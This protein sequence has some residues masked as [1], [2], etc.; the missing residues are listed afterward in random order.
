MTDAPRRILLLF[1]IFAVATG[2][3]LALR[4]RGGYGLFD[5]LRGR[6]P[7]RETV[8]TGDG[9]FSLP[10]RAAVAPEDVPVL[11]RMSDEI[12]NV[13]ER[14]LP[15]VVSIAASEVE[16]AGEGGEPSVARPRLGAGVIVTTDGHVMTNYHVVHGVSGVLVRLANDRLLPAQIVGASPRAD[17]A[18][19]KIITPEPETFQALP[20]IADSDT[21]RAG[22]FVLSIGNPYG[23]RRSVALGN[24]SAK[25]RRFSDGSA[26]L[27]QVSTPMVPGNSGGPL[28]NVFGEIIGINTAIYRQNQRAP[29]W[30]AVGMAVVANDARDTLLAILKR[31]KPVYGYLGV[32]VEIPAI[33][34]HLRAFDTDMKYPMQVAG[35]ESGSPAETAGLRRGDT[36]VEF[37][38]EVPE[39]FK[40]LK[41]LIREQPV[42]GDVEILVR[43]GSEEI[44]LKAKMAELDPQALLARAVGV[45]DKDASAYVKGALGA[46]VRNLNAAEKKQLRLQPGE[47]GLIVA[48]VH[49]GHPAEGRL[50]KGDFIQICNG[51]PFAN[52]AQFAKLLEERPSPRVDLL[53]TRIFPGTGRINLLVEIEPAADDDL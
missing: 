41:K 7:P 33:Y 28:V 8:D 48:E 53:V 31:G 25:E 15:A 51:V 6:T 21:V 42:G 4:E 13:T 27:F 1:A 24:I 50:Y 44:P 17:I 20:F 47:G 30:S 37:A 52:V 11:A 34:I 3:L 35:V 2:V 39:N 12:A 46:V 32:H 10:Q 22:E 29:L 43:R 18:V 23:L 38:G 40:E 26:D 9:Q 14:V 36:I 5:L 45:T 49:A 16:K 19:L